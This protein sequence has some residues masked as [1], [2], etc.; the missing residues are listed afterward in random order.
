MPS[1]SMRTMAREWLYNAEYPNE[2][3]SQQEVDD[4]ATLLDKVRG[5]DLRE[6]AAIVAWLRTAPI[7]TGLTHRNVADAIER[8]AHLER[9]RPSRRARFTRRPVPMRARVMTTAAEWSPTMRF[10]AKPLRPIRRET[11]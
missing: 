6:R 8:G 5:A 11:P 10:D 7:T 2:C 4:L 3:A 1:E 9:I